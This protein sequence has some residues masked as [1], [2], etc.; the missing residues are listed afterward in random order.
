M[1]FKNGTQY[2][3]SYSLYS[4]LFSIFSISH[5]SCIYAWH[6]YEVSRCRYRTPDHLPVP[7]PMTEVYDAAVDVDDVEDVN[8]V[9][10]VEAS[11]SIAAA[12]CAAACS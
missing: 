5:T 9:D 7:A 12:A 10:C 4:I 6:L 3:R 1:N 11:V 8:D 2:S